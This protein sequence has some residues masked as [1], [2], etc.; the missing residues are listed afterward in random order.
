MDMKIILFPLW[1]LAGLIIVPWLLGFLIGL[2]ISGSTV[3]YFKL[4]FLVVG[5]I[6]AKRA[7]R[8][9]GWGMWGGALIVLLEAIFGLN[10]PLI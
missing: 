6:F 10:V 1:F 4:A 5:G 2:V 8:A 9:L 7:H 3:A